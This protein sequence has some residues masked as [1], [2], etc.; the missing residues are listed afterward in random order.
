VY[1]LNAIFHFY[2]KTIS[3][4]ILVSALFSAVL[5]STTASANELPLAPNWQLKTQAGDDISLADFKGKPVILHFWATWCPYCKKLQPE[6][7]RLQKQYQESDVEIVAISFNEDE[8]AL[9][10][11]ELASRGYSFKTAIDGEKVA[12]Q[13]DVRGTPTTYFLNRSGEV[14]FKSTSSDITDPRLD[15]ALKEIIKH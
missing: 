1:T 3:L 7:V 4:I 15:L 11:D 6:L 13:Y 5:F 9:P 10:Q 12:A 14:I 2:K 8:G